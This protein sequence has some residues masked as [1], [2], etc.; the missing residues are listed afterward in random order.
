MAGDLLERFI[1][2]MQ[3]LGFKDQDIITIVEDAV[4][5]P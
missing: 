1:R 5:R 4:K 2:G 3:E